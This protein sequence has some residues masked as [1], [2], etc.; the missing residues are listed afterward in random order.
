MTL[1][2][3]HGAGQLA[4]YIYMRNFAHNLES[5]SYCQLVH[6]DLSLPLQRYCV[7]V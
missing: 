3:L 6:L 7:W 4:L 2:A 1:T 5:Q